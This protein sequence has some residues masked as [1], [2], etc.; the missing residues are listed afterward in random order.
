MLVILEMDSSVLFSEQTFPLS[1][2]VGLRIPL[3]WRDS[4]H[5]N[6]RGSKFVLVLTSL[7]LPGVLS[8]IISWI[9][10]PCVMHLLLF[11]RL[12]SSGVVLPVA[13]RL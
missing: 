12:S 8:C 11:I 3:M 6:N 13:D 2:V 7:M 1:A 5:F 10:Y 4:D 9:W